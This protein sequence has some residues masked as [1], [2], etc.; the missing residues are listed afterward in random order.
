MS[1]HSKWANNKHKK[2]KN[3]AAKQSLWGKIAKEI[4]VAAKLGGGDPDGNP[5]LRAAM[6]KARSNS[7]PNR[8]IESAI[9]IGVGNSDTSNMESMVYEGRGPAGTAFIVTALTDNKTRTV[10]AVRNIF[11]KAGGSL[12]ETNSVAWDFKLCGQI[13]VEKSAVEEEKLMDIALEAGA[14][15]IDSEGENYEITTTFENFDAVSRALDA[16]KIPMLSAETAYV[17]SNP[18]AVDAATAQKIQNLVDKFEENDDV[19]DVYH[20]AEFPEDF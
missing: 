17:P 10:A 13:V 11:S 15:D 12:G 16:A 19:Q 3:D 9:A 1:G 18:N 20:N 8:N 6:L 14:D 4:T 5:R 2:M 7:M